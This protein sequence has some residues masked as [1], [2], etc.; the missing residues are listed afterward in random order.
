MP[1]AITVRIMRILGYAN[2]IS[3]MRTRCFPI[4]RTGGRTWPAGNLAGFHDTSTTYTF[5]DRP[6]SDL[7]RVDESRP[8]RAKTATPARDSARDAG[9]DELTPL[10][11]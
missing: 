4:R 8:D 1:D 6:K 3:R 10:D 5:R 7:I 9:H 11:P 2:S